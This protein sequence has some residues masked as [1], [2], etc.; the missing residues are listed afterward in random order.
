MARK[1]TILQSV[2]PYHITARCINQEW[3][4]LDLELV[5]S[6]FGDYLTILKYEFNFE[7]IS[8]VLLNNHFHM[9]VKT[10][11]A[12]LSEGMNYFMREVSREISYKSGRINQTF[13]GPYHWCLLDSY[14]YFLNSYKYVYRNPVEAGLATTCESY[15]YSS[16]SRLLGFRRINFPIETDTILLNP[17]FQIEALHWLNNGMSDLHQHVAFALKKR[18][19]R[20]RKNIGTR[21]FL[22]DP[23]TIY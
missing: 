11:D 4:E 23:E 17:D 19:F 3:F 8:F 20:Y 18:V 21:T 12:N 13:G 16:L 10:P 6:I 1:K 14:R 7:I 22:I 9:L 2:F 15:S 5:W